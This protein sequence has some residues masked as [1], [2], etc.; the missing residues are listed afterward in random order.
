MSD[1]VIEQENRP[2]GMKMFFLGALIGVA[3]VGG[4]AAT[5]YAVFGPKIFQPLVKQVAVAQDSS[6]LHDDVS[7]HVNG[8]GHKEKHVEG[9]RRG[10]GHGASDSKLSHRIDGL[11]VNPANTR[12]TR[13]LL[14]S[15]D[16]QVPTE[17]DVQQLQAHDT[18]L[19]HVVIRLLGSKTV[20][21]LSDVSNW[22]ALAEEL[23]GVIAATVPNVQVAQ[24]VFPEYVIQ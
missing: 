14:V 1:N 17:A 2:F 24:V 6:E 19:R 22:D 11:I 21:F 23:K 12:G 18:A 5:A 10:N 20:G 4:G 15:L 7:Q 16:I 3:C 13:Y 9:R 8:S